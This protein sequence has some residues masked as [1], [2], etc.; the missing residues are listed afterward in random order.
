[1]AYRCYLET[2]DI[3]AELL[4]SILHILEE[5]EAGTA[6]TEQYGVTFL[7]HFMTSLN[8]ILHGMCVGF[9]HIEV[10][11]GCMKL[12]VVCSEIYYSCAFLSHELMD[13]GVIITLILASY[14]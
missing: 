9:R 8:A 4:A 2:F 12:A 6:W 7:C 3:L 5:V 13:G 10:I 11:E 14:N 1:M